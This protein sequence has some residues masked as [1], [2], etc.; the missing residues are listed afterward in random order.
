[1][2]RLLSFSHSAYHR[3]VRTKV[4]ER[5]RTTLYEVAVTSNLLESSSML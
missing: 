4:S 1:M 5:L 3:W 2:M